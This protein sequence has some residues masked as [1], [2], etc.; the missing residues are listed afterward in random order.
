VVVRTGFMTAKGELV[1]SIL[2]PKP[3][4]GFKFYQDSIRFIIFLFFT[5]ALGMAY[6]VHVYVKRLVSTIILKIRTAS[7]SHMK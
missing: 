1:R 6:C 5:A 7:C 3:L 4:S 2:F